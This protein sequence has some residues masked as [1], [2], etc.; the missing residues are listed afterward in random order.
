MANQEVSEYPVSRLEVKRFIQS[1][2][3]REN[4]INVRHQLQAHGV[5]ALDII[6]SQAPDR[7][8]VAGV[9][10]A[11]QWPRLRRFIVESGN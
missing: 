2:Q 5:V 1:V 4:N 11:E 8:G 3:L 10:I 7:H 9:R 6:V